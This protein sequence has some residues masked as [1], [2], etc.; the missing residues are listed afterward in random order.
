MANKPTDYDAADV[1]QL[2][3]MME[4]V[5]K[6]VERQRTAEE[7]RLAASKWRTTFDAIGDALALMDQEGNILQCNQAMADLVG[8]PFTE[9]IGRR[10]WE[11]VH[12]TNGPINDCPMVR[13]RQSH[14]REESVLPAGEKLV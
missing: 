13:M 1:K 7:L 11:A 10:C 6:I 3:L 9:I 12:G 8:K 14:Q 4:M 5:W 2:T